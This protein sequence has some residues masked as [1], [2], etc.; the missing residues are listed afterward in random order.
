MIYKNKKKIKEITIDGKKILQVYSGDK[1]VWPSLGD[2]YDVKLV[3]ENGVKSITIDGKTYTKDTVE[4]ENKSSIDTQLVTNVRRYDVTYEPVEMMISTRFND[5]ILEYLVEYEDGFYGDTFGKIEEHEE[6]NEGE[7]VIHPIVNEKMML[8][9]VHIKLSPY[10]QLVKIGNEIYEDG[11]TL[12]VYP[13]E[14]IRY[15]AFVKNKSFIGSTSEITEEC[16]ITINA[17]T[18][19][20]LKFG[21]GIESITVNNTEYFNDFKSAD[22]TIN[23][24]RGVSSYDIQATEAERYLY[25]DL[26]EVNWSC[27][28]DESLLIDASEGSFIMDELKPY[29]I[30]PITSYDNIP[31]TIIPSDDISLIVNDVEYTNETKIEVLRGTTVEWYA[32][33]KYGY[34]PITMNSLVAEDTEGYTISISNTQMKMPIIIHFD[35]GVESITIDNELTYVKS[36]FKYADVIC[37]VSRA[38]DY[39]EL[40]YTPIQ[41]KFYIYVNYGEHTWIA[42]LEDGFEVEEGSVL[43]GTLSP[44]TTNEINF[45]IKQIDNE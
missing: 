42:T 19:L 33:T 14:P 1:L 38:I 5:S 18:Q 28:H 10:V 26:G 37:S 4:D 43:S 2:I 40:E 9:P 8:I 7:Y 16:T 32:N 34:R 25:L 13:N 39:Y 24:A 3:F 35:N 22:V 27:K 41:E 45:N 11:S 30:S 29:V 20:W 17:K 44:E 31:I 23:V 12:Y 15:E 21:N 6:E 36:D